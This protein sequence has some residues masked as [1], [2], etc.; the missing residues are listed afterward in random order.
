VALAGVGVL[1]G[2]V[3]VGILLSRPDA[4][5]ATGPA[6]TTVVTTIVA[7]LPTPTVKPSARAAGTPFS[8][9]L[10]VAVLQYAYASS[11]PAADWQGRGALEAWLD[12]YTDGGAGKLSVQAGQFP[13]A[14]EATA[15]A[16]TL[17]A[18]LPTA[19]P[20]PAP[21]GAVVLPRTG[22]VVVAGT[23]SGSYT[24]ADGGDGTGIAVWTNG[25]A[26]FRLVAP[27]ADI[28]NAYGAYP[29]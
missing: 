6:P 17:T 27:L 25:T 18:A 13:T 20:T 3:V 22:Q 12:A 11:Q 9:A 29:L 5:R 21:T 26:V 2:V 24:I 15:F 16:A 4:V 1:I 7:P 23:V 10:P 14:D 8:A 28:L 19:A